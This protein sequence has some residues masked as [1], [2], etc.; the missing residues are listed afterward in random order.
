[1]AG[2]ETGS[3]LGCNL[4]INFLHVRLLAFGMGC[5]KFRERIGVFLF[6]AL[7][8]A[9]LSWVAASRGRIVSIGSACKANFLIVREVSK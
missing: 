9:A 2:K 6:G 1:M 7:G 4:R 3:W 8:P 5:N